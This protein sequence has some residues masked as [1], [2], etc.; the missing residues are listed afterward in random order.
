MARPSSLR[1]ASVVFVVFAFVSSACIVEQLADDVDNN[2]NEDI[3]G[4]GPSGGSGASDPGSKGT[5]S[6]PGSTGSTSSSS[7]SS[8]GNTTSSQPVGNGQPGSACN[9]DSDCNAVEG[10]DGICV[11][12]VCMTKASGPCS[13]GG[14][15]VECNAGS[16]CWGLQGQEGYICWPNCADFSCAGGCDADGSC[17]PSADTNCGYSCGSYCS[18]QAGDCGAGYSCLDGKCVQ[19]VDVGNGPGPGPGPTCNNLPPRDCTGSAAYCG[20]LVVFN[21]RT[22]A[23]YDDYPINGETANNQYRS[24]LRRD[25][26]MLLDYATARTYCKSAGWAAGN[27]GA[28]GLGDMSEA[29]GAIP[30][31][32]INQPGHPKNTHTNGFDIDIGYYQVNTPDNKLRPIC[33][34][35]NYHCTKKPHL[36]DTWR[37]ALFLGSVFESKRVRVIGVDGQ[38]G[39]V[40]TAAIGQLCKDG[41]LDSFACN[42][43]NLGFE[44]EDK[45]Y[46][47]YYFHHHHAH[48]SMC[49]GSAPCVNANSVSAMEPISPGLT[50]IPVKHNPH[51]IW[52][53][54]SL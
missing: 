29:N 10:H 19:D 38:A 27:G 1:L 39:T 17:G 16:Q 34:Y 18:C 15:T 22:T 45:G 30:G 44:V 11:Y 4:L 43:V 42:H 37:E 31:T 7:T 51:M 52:K 46:G 26:M 23:H 33:E 25:L 24:Y 21:P 6:D 14:S 9:C 47:W 50:I 48:V 2:Q 13:A 12:G 5:G 28:L 41:W 20:E 3:D 40:L 54:G 49:P 53:R 35:S 36:L 32:S 8:S